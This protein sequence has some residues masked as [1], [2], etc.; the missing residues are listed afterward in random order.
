MVVPE[1]VL[2]E[3]KERKQVQVHPRKRGGVPK[4]MAV[5]LGEKSWTEAAA[6]DHSLSPC[7]LSWPLIFLLGLLTIFSQGPMCIFLLPTSLI[8]S[9]GS[10]ISINIKKKKV[11]ISSVLAY[12]YYLNNDH[13]HNNPTSNLSFEFHILMYLLL[14]LGDLLKA[15]QK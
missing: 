14:L 10:Q 6:L 2:R 5:N 7:Q 15:S 8:V 12:K 9:P 4:A 3:Q 13:C 1:L 11:Q